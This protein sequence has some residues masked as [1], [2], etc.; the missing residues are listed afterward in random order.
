MR[1][2]SPHLILPI[3]TIVMLKLI[4]SGIE[5]NLGPVTLKIDRENL[6]HGTSDII[7]VISSLV[8]LLERWEVIISGGRR[9]VI[10]D[11]NI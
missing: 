3:L 5:I 9:Q 10:V 4:I 8:G 7:A 11:Q 1:S 6:P 2:D